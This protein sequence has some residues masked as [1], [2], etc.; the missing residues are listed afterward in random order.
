[1]DFKSPPRELTVVSGGE[2]VQL[3]VPDSVLAHVPR[4]TAELPGG[5]WASKSLS[6]T[7]E[8]PITLDALV[9]LLT[10]LD[11]RN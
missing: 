11:H 7:L 10:C 8:P 1:M 3:F 4:L 5:A 9:W 2:T 6:L